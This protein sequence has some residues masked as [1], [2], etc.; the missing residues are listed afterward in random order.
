MPTRILAG[1]HG[2]KSRWTGVVIVP[3]RT[4][5]ALSGLR[6]DSAQRTVFERIRDLSTKEQEWLRDDTTR[7]MLLP[8]SGKLHEV[9][10]QGY[11]PDGWAFGKA[12]E[13]NQKL[14]NDFQTEGEIENQLVEVWLYGGNSQW[15]SPI[16][17]ALVGRIWI[18]GISS[19]SGDLGFLFDPRI[20]RKGIGGEAI[21]QVIT[22]AFGSYAEGG[23]ALSQLTLGTF[24][25]NI[26]MR[27][28]AY[29]HGFRVFDV[30]EPFEVW[31]PGPREGTRQA[32]MV[33]GVLYELRKPTK[34]Q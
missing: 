13:R 27:K 23:L 15:K 21:S 16:L 24:E 20:Q 22:Y 28:L 6:L 19:G 25:D 34:R 29:R 8:Q 11:L 3:I 5:P 32:T 4:E 14:A 2:H 12:L 17:H 1:R 31:R 30:T 9:V 18:R 26:G 7:W 10:A 33:R